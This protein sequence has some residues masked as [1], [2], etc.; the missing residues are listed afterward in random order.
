MALK[1]DTCAPTPPSPFQ[2]TP[3]H[4]AQASSERCNTHRMPCQR[5]PRQT[6]TLRRLLDSRYRHRAGFPGHPSK[7]CN[8]LTMQ[9]QRHLAMASPAR[10]LLRRPRHLKNEVS[11]T[12]TKIRNHECGRMPLP[13]R[14]H[15]RSDS[16]QTAPQWFGQEG[17]SGYPDRGPGP[18]RTFRPSERSQA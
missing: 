6:Y 12:L 16:L 8:Q 11:W 18:V 5:Q 2:P 14:H 13:L 1:H 4:P 7:L 17:Q 10:I 9:S 15:V 3:D